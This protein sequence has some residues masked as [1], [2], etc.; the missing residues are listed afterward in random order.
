MSSEIESKLSAYLREKFKASYDQLCL[1]NNYPKDHMWSHLAWPIFVKTVKINQIRKPGRF[2]INI[3]PVWKFVPNFLSGI[4]FEG[5]L[6]S[7]YI[8]LNDLDHFLSQLRLNEDL[9][10]RI[11]SNLFELITSCFESNERNIPSLPIIHVNLKRHIGSFMNHVRYKSKSIKSMAP[12]SGI[13]FNKSIQFGNVFFRRS[14]YED[15]ENIEV[16]KHNSNNEH[17]LFDYYSSNSPLLVTKHEFDW[18]PNPKDI[19]V[20]ANM[21]RLHDFSNDQYRLILAAIRLSVSYP[22]NVGVGIIFHLDANWTTLNSFRSITEDPSP[23]FRPL[24]I[25]NSNTLKRDELYFREK[26]SKKELNKVLTKFELLQKLIL[27]KSTLRNNPY[28]E[29]MNAIELYSKAIE[30]YSLD[31]ILLNIIK[32]FEALG[33]F[34]NS[35]IRKNTRCE[36]AGKIIHSL[37]IKDK[38]EKSAIGDGYGLRSR[39]AAHSPED[40]PIRKKFLEELILLQK[41]LILNTLNTYVV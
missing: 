25:N 21:E 32:S 17:K 39:R 26:L 35:I 22:M 24:R 5:K 30:E 40:L 6:F 28:V 2:E 31:W 20:A 11:R 36:S 33:N 23:N 9:D 4:Q 15:W 3:I 10:H 1:L 27:T 18:T 8:E 41:K 34:R 16:I 38:N 14:T 29:L 19:S 12:I 37:E 13:E 7:D